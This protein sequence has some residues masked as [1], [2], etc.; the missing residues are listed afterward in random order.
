MSLQ[1]ASVMS[2][3]PKYRQIVPLRLLVCL[4]LG[5]DCFAFRGEAGFPGVS[6]KSR[7]VDGD[8]ILIVSIPRR[9]VQHLD[10]AGSRDEME[11]EMEE[12]IEEEYQS[13]RTGQPEEG[14]KSGANETN[15]AND[16]ED[17]KI[18]WASLRLCI[19]VPLLSVR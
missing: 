13:G 10:L 7:I 1:L 15:D 18:D 19:T 2:T 16:T 3:P 11:M 14:D 9:S 5:V 4:G 6:G 8:G 17:T 12:E